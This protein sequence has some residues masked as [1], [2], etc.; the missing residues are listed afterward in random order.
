MGRQAPGSAAAEASRD[1]IRFLSMRREAEIGLLLLVR[2]YG[3]NRR[4]DQRGGV[5]FLLCPSTDHRVRAEGVEQYHIAAEERFFRI[6][7]GI[8]PERRLV[9]S[10][11]N[12]GISRPE[13]HGPLGTS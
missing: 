5:L 6:Q 4:D 13:T 10:E 9:D 11:K 1:E 12:P 8:Q 7:R 2:V 3:G